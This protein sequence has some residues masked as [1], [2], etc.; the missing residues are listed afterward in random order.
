MEEQ[1]KKL[2]DKFSQHLKTNFE[3]YCQRHHIEVNIENFITYL[4]DRELISAPTIRR[5]TI[6]QEF[7]QLYPKHNFHKSNT[8][9]TL[10]DLFNLSSRHVWSLIKYSQ[11]PDQRKKWD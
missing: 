6:L 11:R 10:A 3:D 7:E 2:L 9:D 8:I 4:I 5:Y 1:G